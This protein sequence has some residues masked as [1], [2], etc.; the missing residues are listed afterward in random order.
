MQ[1]L[2]TNAQENKMKAFINFYLSCKNIRRD[3]K[4]QM[5]FED[6]KFPFLESKNNKIKKLTEEIKK[7]SE[8]LKVIIETNTKTLL[9]KNEAF[10]DEE[11]Y[12]SLL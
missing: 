4:E 2:Y 7:N 6:W 12:L 9:Y 11:A 8:E 1:K 5:M 3:L 10:E